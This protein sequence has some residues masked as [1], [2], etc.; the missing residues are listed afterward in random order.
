MPTVLYVLDAPTSDL[1][2]RI[3]AIETL[4]RLPATKETAKAVVRYLS[5]SKLRGNSLQ[6]IGAMGSAAEDPVADL[7]KQGPDQRILA[8][9]LLARL[10]SKKS[11]PVMENYL[12]S[13]T[14]ARCRAVG[15]A[16]LNMLR[17]RV[18]SRQRQVQDKGNYDDSCRNDR[19]LSRAMRRHT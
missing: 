15:T 16:A 11:V 7:L 9:A 4:G 1:N 17:Q 2:D 19:S 8:S 13:E 18:S 14:D 10:G 5:D 12:R 3:L 6:A